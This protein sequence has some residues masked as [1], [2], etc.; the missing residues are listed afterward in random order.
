MAPTSGWDTQETHLQNLHVGVLLEALLK[1]TFKEM[2]DIG[3]A[4]Q[5]EKLSWDAFAP[6]AS[7]DL[8]RAGWVAQHSYLQLGKRFRPLTH[9]LT[10][11]WTGATSQW[12]EK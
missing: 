5:R 7:T 12:G 2:T 6:E 4:R 1:H 11:H 8:L 10:S 3:L 9:T